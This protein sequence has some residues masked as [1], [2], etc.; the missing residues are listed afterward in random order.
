MHVQFVTLM[1]NPVRILGRRA[2][3]SHTFLDHDVLFVDDEEALARHRNGEWQG[4]LPR[5]R[6]GLTDCGALCCDLMQF[7]AATLIDLLPPLASL[8]DALQ[9]ELKRAI[10]AKV[11]EWLEASAAKVKV[12]VTHQQFALALEV[13]E[14]TAADPAASGERLIADWRA[15]RN[16]AV[17]LKALFADGT[18]PRGIV[19]P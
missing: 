8:P 15:V 4:M 1:D 2:R 12:H 16:T 14:S 19:V 18:I 5:L 7:S 13:F 9:D 6:K 17:A 3:L 10:D 11:G